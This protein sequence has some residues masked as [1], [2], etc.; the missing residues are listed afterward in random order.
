MIFNTKELEEAQQLLLEAINAVGYE[1]IKLEEGLGKILAED[2]YAPINIPSFR[3]SPLDGYA[4][5]AVDTQEATLKDPRLIEVIDCIQAGDTRSHILLQKGQAVKIMTGAPLPREADL[6]IKKEDIELCDNKI[7]IKQKYESA[8]V[9][10][11]GDDIPQGQ[12][13][14]ARSEEITPYHLGVLAAL[15]LTSFKVIKAPRVAVISTGSE[16]KQPGQPLEF[17][18]IY[19]SNLYSLKALLGKLGVQANTL[20]NVGD[21]EEILAQSIQGALQDNEMIITTGG[22]SVGDYD[23]IHRVLV[24]LGAKILFN[25]VAIKPGSPVVA[26][27][28]DGKIILGLSGNPAAALISFELL[29]KPMIQ[30]LR[31]L[32]NWQFDIV[33]A[34]L[35]DGF[36]KKSPQRRFLRIKVK[37]VKDKWLATQTGSQ[38]SSILLSMVNC[39][40]LVDIPAGSGPIKKGSVVRAY[41][42]E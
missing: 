24:D 22:A 41:L 4:L 26:G 9:I 29:A 15:G 17:G 19:N 12:R 27:I 28:I 5:R 1:E 35:V 13:I 39:N 14:F 36:N 34:C 8:N 33:E 10:P 30:K 3:K 23:Y 20:Q 18:Q 2:I 42:L 7:F 32:E 37:W 38:D 25:R 31:G 6:V 21:D 16:L 11:I 40:A